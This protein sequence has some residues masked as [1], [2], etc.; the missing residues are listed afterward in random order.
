M[1]SQIKAGKDRVIL[2]PKEQENKR[3]SIGPHSA[4]KTKSGLYVPVYDQNEFEP[5]V[6]DQYAYVVAVPESARERVD[7]NKWRT[8]EII[9]KEGDLCLVT[10]SLRKRHLKIGWPDKECISIPY[11]H[12]YAIVKD[13]KLIPNACHNILEP[14]FVGK[15]EHTDESGVVVLSTR[16][17]S[18]SFARAKWISQSLKDKGVKEGDIV[19]LAPDINYEVKFQQKEYFI[20]D[21]DYVMCVVN[22]EIFE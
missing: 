13:N 15:E 12:I 7:T 3:E 8:H 11:H 1:T 17:R 5:D 6:C 19:G 2:R 20:V 16:T 21:T 14:I 18:E 10:H 9:I 4:I 22:P